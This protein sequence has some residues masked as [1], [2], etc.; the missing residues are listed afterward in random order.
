M[1]IPIHWWLGSSFPQW[2]NILSNQPAESL[3][4]RKTQAAVPERSVT[5]TRQWDIDSIWLGANNL[6]AIR[7]SGGFR[8]S[9]LPPHSRNLSSDQVVQ[10]HGIDLM[11]TRH[12]QLGTFT[13]A[14]VRFS[15]FLFFPQTAAGKHKVKAS[16]NSLSL[17]RQRDL[18]DGIILPAAYE[19]LPD[20]ARQEIPSSFD[21]LYAKSHSFQEKPGTG[22][23]KAE[24]DGRAYYLTYHVPTQALSGFWSSIVQRANRFTITSRQGEAFPYSV[25]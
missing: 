2:Q 17:E 12:I 20:Y 23:W 25:K 9:F 15:V 10:P 22:R 3:S 21:L 14:N 16:A 7:S 11:H 13:T 5:I 18:Y 1:A 19:T 6:S 8:L 24:D 4:F